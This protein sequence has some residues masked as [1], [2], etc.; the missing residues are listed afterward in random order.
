MKLKIA[1]MEIAKG[2]YPEPK[3]SSIELRLIHNRNSNVLLSRE[4]SIIDLIRDILN[5]NKNK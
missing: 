5:E 1:K 2:I 3:L 4:I